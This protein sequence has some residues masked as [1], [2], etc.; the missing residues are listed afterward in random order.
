MLVYYSY[1]LQVSLF[2]SFS[3]LK[4]EA[5]FARNVFF[6][7]VLLGDTSKENVCFFNEYAIERLHILH[8]HTDFIK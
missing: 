6:L 3:T 7:S 8:N 5:I 4:L 2:A 1:L